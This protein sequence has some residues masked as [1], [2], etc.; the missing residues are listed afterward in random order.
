LGY[1]PILH[2]TLVFGGE[3]R[4]RNNAALD[5]THTS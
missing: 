5:R 2:Q 3:I 4:T 1:E